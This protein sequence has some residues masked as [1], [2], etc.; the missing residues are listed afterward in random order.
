MFTTSNMILLHVS[1]LAGVAEGGTG[2]PPVL[3]TDA[4]LCRHRG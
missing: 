2:Q 4:S 1:C 3:M